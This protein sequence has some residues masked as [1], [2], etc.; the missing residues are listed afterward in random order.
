MRDTKWNPARGVVRL[1]QPEFPFQSLLR[2]DLG[3]SP[4]LVIPATALEIRLE[5]SFWV[6]NDKEYSGETLRA[7]IIS[8]LANYPDAPISETAKRYATVPT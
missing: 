6:L 7:L 3:K 4:G 5:N 8:I 2:I 1:G